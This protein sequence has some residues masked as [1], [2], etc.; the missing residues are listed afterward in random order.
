MFPNNSHRT[1]PAVAVYTVA[2]VAGL[3]AS[4]PAGRARAVFNGTPHTDA[5]LAMPAIHA[6]AESFDQAE[7]WRETLRR[8]GYEPAVIYALAAAH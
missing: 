3:Y 2:V 4:T 5:R 6:R 8:F 7:R 1:S